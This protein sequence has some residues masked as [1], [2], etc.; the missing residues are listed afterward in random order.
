MDD[1][2]FKGHKDRIT[3]IFNDEKDFSQLQNDFEKKLDVSK[4]F[5]NSTKKTP[6][7]FKGINLSEEQS[8]KLLNS[9]SDKTGIESSL[10]IPEKKLDDKIQNPNELKTTLHK[11]SLRSGQFIHYNGNVIILGDVNP[12]AEIIAYG[13]VI[14]MGTIRGLVHAGC[15]GNKNCIISALSL[16]P[17]QLRIANIITRLPDNEI[18][19]KP[20]YA[21]IDDDKLY[22]SPLQ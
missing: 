8:L 21:Y 6:I 1:I 15:N 10:F 9:I 19:T 14:V 11:N 12:G 3:I 7:E 16:L 2:I 13:N 4:N 22:I 20:S 5:F 18:V 17:V